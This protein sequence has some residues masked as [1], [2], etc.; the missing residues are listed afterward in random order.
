MADDLLFAYSLE[1]GKEQTDNETK[2]AVGNRRL[3][4]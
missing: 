1:I 3:A 4:V 2:L